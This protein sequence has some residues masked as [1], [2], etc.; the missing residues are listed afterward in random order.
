MR[1]SEHAPCLCVC[2]YVCV[3]LTAAGMKKG[4][5]CSP[6]NISPAILL[7]GGLACACPDSYSED[8]HCSREGLWADGGK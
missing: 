2:V 5:G 7:G 8:Q 3:C 6:S 4:Q 1:E